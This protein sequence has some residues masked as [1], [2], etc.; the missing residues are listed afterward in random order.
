MGLDDD[1]CYLQYNQQHP[2]TQSPPVP[3]VGHA[4]CVTVTYFGKNYSIFVIIC[5][6][7]ISI[8]HYIIELLLKETSN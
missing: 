8:K 6:N 4:L 5:P 1:H 3:F 2:S 7:F